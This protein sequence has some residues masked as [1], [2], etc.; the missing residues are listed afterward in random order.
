MTVEEPVA[1]ESAGGGF[2]S[3]E[4]ATGSGGGSQFADT[5]PASPEEEEEEPVSENLNS[6]FSSNPK[7][8]PSLLPFKVL[9]MA[10][11]GVHNICIMEKQPFSLICD[12]YH[13]FME[14]VLTD[15]TIKVRYDGPG[16]EG[17]PQLR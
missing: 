13:Q 8:V 11:G 1:V 2:S 7:L 9:K 5:E 17:R 4:R 15:F 3:G 14:N 10:S 12:L 16:S 6:L